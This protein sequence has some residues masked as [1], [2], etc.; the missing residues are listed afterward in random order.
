MSKQLLTSF[1]VINSFIFPGNRFFPV[2][3][4]Q[5]YFLVV[6]YMGTIFSPIG[7]IYAIQNYAHQD[8]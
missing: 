8:T 6:N 2:R 5:F 1:G 7:V 3:Q 4:F